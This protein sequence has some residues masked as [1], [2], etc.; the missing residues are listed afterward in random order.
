[1]IEKEN[2]LF[3]MF[4]VSTMFIMV[5]FGNIGGNLSIVQVYSHSF[6]PNTL[7]SFISSADQFITEANLAKDNLISNNTDMAQK[8]ANEANSIFYWELMAEI[9]ERDKKV[10]D[11]LKS[12][13]DELQNISSFFADP[14]I[15]SISIQSANDQEKLEQIHQLVA[16]INTNT[17][18]IINTTISQKGVED[19]NLL[20]QV[21]SFLSSIFAEQ[22]SDTIQS[23]QSMRIAE[24]LDDVLRNYGDAYGV[25]YDMTDMSNMAMMDNNSSMTSH[26]MM[27]MDMDM[28]DSDNLI[29]NVANYQSA[30]GLAERL[31]KIFDSEVEPIMTNNEMSVYSTNI[32]RG[33]MELLSSIK[34]KASPM[35]VMMIVHTQ[36]HPNLMEAFGLRLL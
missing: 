25:D 7:A 26:D 15:N 3:F 28:D 27:N 6:T 35:D 20:N 17:N 10:S 30:Q 21:V 36:I 11:D 13:V 22:T 24:L 34:D 8:H 4:T 29:I 32:E 2:S 12:S 5:L 14:N 9:A 31:V 16:K 19:S 33:L 18:S 1:M 23:I